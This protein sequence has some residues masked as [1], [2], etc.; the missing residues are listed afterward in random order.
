MR[1]GNLY[2]IGMVQHV[3]SPGRGIASSDTSVQ[4]VVK[5]WDENLLILGVD[6]KIA[7]V[8]KKGDYALADY[9]PV[10][11]ASSNRKLLLIKLLPVEVGSK[12]WAEFQDEFDRRRTRPAQPPQPQQPLRYIR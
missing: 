3:I 4:A 8:I 5:M 2:H 7:R 10:S 9:N 11:A 12:I 6:K 1:G